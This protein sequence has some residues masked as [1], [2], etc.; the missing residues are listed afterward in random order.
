M[1]SLRKYL[2]E[3]GWRL[4]E[5]SYFGFLYKQFLI[6]SSPTTVHGELV[7][8]LVNRHGIAQWFLLKSP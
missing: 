5:H 1:Y 4:D 6:A 8:E 3:I 7:R 2:L